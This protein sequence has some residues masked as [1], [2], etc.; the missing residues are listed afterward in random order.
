VT[1]RAVSRVS[2][3]G[4]TRDWSGRNVGPPPWSSS[5]SFSYLAFDRAPHHAIVQEGWTRGPSLTR[6]LIRPRSSFQPA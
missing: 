3:I 5:Q 4:L 6:V 2:G 1:M